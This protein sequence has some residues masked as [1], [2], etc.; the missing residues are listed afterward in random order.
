MQKPS[1]QI[2]ETTIRLRR[3]KDSA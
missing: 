3:T 2:S 1:M